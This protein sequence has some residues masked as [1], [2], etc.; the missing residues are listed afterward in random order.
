LDRVALHGQLD[1]GVCRVD[2]VAGRVAH[3]LHPHFL[4]N[5][6]FHEAGVKGM[7]KVVESQMTDAGIPERRL[8]R[9]LYDAHRMILE[10]D[11]ET[12]AST[13]TVQVLVEPGGK[14]N[15]AGLALGCFRACHI[16]QPQTTMS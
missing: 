6:G 9:P 4:Q 13:P 1:V 11:D 3:Q 5:T 12:L 8:P 16:E 15:F 7:A 14:R 10:V 2:F